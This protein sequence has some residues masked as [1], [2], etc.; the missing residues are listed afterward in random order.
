MKRQMKNQPIHTYFISQH[1]PNYYKQIHIVLKTI[2]VRISKTV[3]KTKYA[4]GYNEYTQKRGAISK[5][6]HEFMSVFPPILSYKTHAD[7]AVKIGSSY[8]NSLYED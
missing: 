5:K 4:W 6:N 2:K 3:C 1:L 7:S 8:F